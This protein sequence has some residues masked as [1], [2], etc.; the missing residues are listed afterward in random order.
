M[1]CR[2]WT[3][4]VESVDFIG[5]LKRLDG[6]L[7]GLVLVRLINTPVQFIDIDTQRR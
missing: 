6:N 5:V 3:Y 7:I 4:L 2:C 1:I